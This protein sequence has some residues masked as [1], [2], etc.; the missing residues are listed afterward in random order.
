MH[1]LYSTTSPVS[2]CQ[3]MKLILIN[4]Y[5]KRSDMQAPKTDAGWAIIIADFAELANI[6]MYALFD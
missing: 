1:C 5:L 4:L 3:T 6:N 2:V